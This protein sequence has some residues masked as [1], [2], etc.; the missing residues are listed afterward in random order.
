MEAILIADLVVAIVGTLM[1]GAVGAGYAVLVVVA[2]AVKENQSMDP[3]GTGHEAV[4][5]YFDTETVGADRGV[6]LGHIVVLAAD[7]QCQLWCLLAKMT[8]ELL[9]LE[10]YVIL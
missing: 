7:G 6:V 5:V 10:N 9:E 3:V 2:V 8:D 4:L 1:T